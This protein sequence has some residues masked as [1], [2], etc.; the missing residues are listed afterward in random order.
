[1]VV[2]HLRQASV[3]GYLYPQEPEALREELGRLTRDEPHKTSAIGVIVPHGSY[4]WCGAIV[5]ETFSRVVIPPRCILL[6]PNHMGVGV[7]WSLMVG[8]AYRTP[9]GEVA[10]DE[11]L[12]QALQAVCP[13]LVAD[14]AVHRGEHALEVA[15]PFLQWLGPERL[16]IVPL[17]IGS[18]DPEECQRVADALAEVIRR[19]GEPALLV[20]SADLTH[21]EPLASVRH[22]DAQ[23][24]ET[25]QT[26]DEH[27]LRRQ[28]Q[29]SSTMTCGYGPIACLLAASRRL[30][31]TQAR[32]VRYGTSA[33]G[34]G[35]PNSVIGYAGLI[36]N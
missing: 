36:L 11:A 2:N 16:T 15:L 20:A 1:M 14:D 12:A 10:I 8:G 32:L 6:G 3:A 24:L 34:G 4:R 21:Y 25:L 22:K 13:F 5:G 26:L 17:V 31:A 28:L 23:L 33:E 18:E 35:D 7:P 19:T 29:A 27:R 30:G 9:L